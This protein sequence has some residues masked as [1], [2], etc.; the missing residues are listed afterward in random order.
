MRDGDGHF[1]PGSDVDRGHFGRVDRSRLEVVADGVEGGP[2]A[3][4]AVAQPQPP[5]VLAD[6]QLVGHSLAAAA[7]NGLC[8][9]I[10]ITVGGHP[11]PGAGRSATFE[12]R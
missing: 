9:G 1:V 11:R 3:V 8:V 4:E 7:S 5:H 6:A 10:R 2:V 12:R